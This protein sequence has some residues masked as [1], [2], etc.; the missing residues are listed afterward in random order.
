MLN[1][2]RRRCPQCGSWQAMFEREQMICSGVDTD[3]QFMYYRNA[4]KEFVYL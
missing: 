2:I 3:Q 1:D 4:L